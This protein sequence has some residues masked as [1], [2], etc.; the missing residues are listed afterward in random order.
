VVDVSH[1]R[2]HWW[3]GGCR[4]VAIGFEFSTLEV[5]V[6]S[7]HHL[8]HVFVRFPTERRR[9]AMRRVEVDLLVDVGHDAELHQLFDHFNTG[10]FKFCGEIGHGQYRWQRN[11]FAND[12]HGTPHCDGA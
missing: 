12:G 11:G 10:R 6:G 2:D 3:S 7:L 4:R 8:W 5:G 1:D 9:H